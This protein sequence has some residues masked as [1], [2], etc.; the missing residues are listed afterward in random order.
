MRGPV[1]CKDKHNM[2]V[3]RAWLRFEWK[4][5]DDDSI[6]FYYNTENTKVFWNYNCACLVFFFL[7]TVILFILKD[8]QHAEYLASLKATNGDWI[9]GCGVLDIFKATPQDLPRIKEQVVAH[10]LFRL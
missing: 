1:I 4:D 9:D 7:E 2:N 3:A 6:M 5:V 10:F 8:V